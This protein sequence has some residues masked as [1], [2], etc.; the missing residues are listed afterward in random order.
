MTSGATNHMWFSFLLF[1]ETSM[2]IK[3]IKI[4]I[5][6]VDIKSGGMI[7]KEEDREMPEDAWGSCE[8]DK[9]AAEFDED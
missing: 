6:I 9:A 7:M 2:N 5:I 3:V 1:L 8:K 4:I